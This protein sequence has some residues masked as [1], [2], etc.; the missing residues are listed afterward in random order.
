MELK[1]RVTEY[2]HLG[3]VETFDL[4]FLADAYRR[5]EIADLEP[6]ECHH[7]AKYRYGAGI[8]QLHEELRDVTI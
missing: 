7:E 1:I 4:H 5:D 2:T 8:D 6:H 3:A